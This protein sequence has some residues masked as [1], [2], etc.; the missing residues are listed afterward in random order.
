MVHDSYFISSNTT[1]QI[2]DFHLFKH[3]IAYGS[4]LGVTIIMDS[5][6]IYTELIGLLQTT[7]NHE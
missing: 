2:S 4:F 5:T 1:S 3:L 6:E 7:L